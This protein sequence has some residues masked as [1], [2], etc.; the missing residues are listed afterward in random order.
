MKEDILLLHG[1]KGRGDS[2]WQPWLKAELEKRGH[3]VLAPDLPSSSAPK[4]KEW[5]AEAKKQL[6]SLSAP[7]IIIG[8]SLGGCTLLN[9]LSDPSV[10]S[11]IKHAFLIAPPTNRLERLPEF[12]QHI[13]WGAL[14]Q[15]Q[16]KLSY[17][18]SKDDPLVPKGQFDFF[19]TTL[20]Q[21]RTILLEGEGHFMKKEFPGL[22]EM[23]GFKSSN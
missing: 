21:S 18:Y 3:K 8:H 14:S 20:P 6:A 1:Y 2:V 16:D 12:T 4:L 11:K 23:L 22:L 15:I 13:D 19:K 5:L 17:I 9:L 7:V 10:H